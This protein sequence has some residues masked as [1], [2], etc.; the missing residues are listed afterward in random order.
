VLLLPV[1]A[2]S[3]TS[4]I[5]G[6]AGVA[7][8]GGTATATA[9]ATATGATLAKRELLRTPGAAGTGAGAGAIAAAATATAAGLFTRLEPAVGSVSIYS[10]VQIAAAV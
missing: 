8:T 7:V 6:A 10:V 3:G 4:I 1:L 5:C 2:Y 9:T